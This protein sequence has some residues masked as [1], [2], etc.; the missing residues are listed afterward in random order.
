MSANAPCAPSQYSRLMR[1]ASGARP[2]LTTCS[3]RHRSQHNSSSSSLNSP[4]RLWTP[5]STSSRFNGERWP[6]TLD[7]RWIIACGPWQSPRRRLLPFRLRRTCRPATFI[8]RKRST[9][10]VGVK[11]A[12]QTSTTARVSRTDSQISGACERR[13]WSAAP[14]YSLLGL[15]SRTQHQRQRRHDGLGTVQ[16][17]HLDHAER[18]ERAGYRLVGRLFERG[19]Q[20]EEPARSRSTRMPR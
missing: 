15:V 18:D 20:G 6:S 3:K 10:R 16:H 5:A 14:R 7:P 9:T 2:S 13:S 4:S 8:L 12:S 19:Q 17:G 11:A 1:T